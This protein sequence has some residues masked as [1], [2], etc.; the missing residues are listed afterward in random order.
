MSAVHLEELTMRPNVLLATLTV[1]LV[2][3]CY[4]PTRSPKVEETADTADTGAP[5]DVSPLSATALSICGD[6]ET[7]L[8]I[9]SAEEA[10]ET[11]GLSLPIVELSFL[12]QQ[13]R[14]LAEY[15]FDLGEATGNFCSTIDE[16]PTTG[17]IHVIARCVDVHSLT[18]TGEW[19][20]LDSA[21]G[22]HL[23]AEDVY[24][25]DGETVF[26][27]DGEAS[28]VYE[29][30][31]AFSFV[32][33]LFIDNHDMGDEPWTR[34]LEIYA[35]RDGSNDTEAG[36]MEVSSG[37]GGRTGG[38][39]LSVAWQSSDTCEAEGTGETA[40]QGSSLV[41]LT[42]DA[43]TCDGCADVTIDGVAADPYCD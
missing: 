25:N 31:D 9:A 21:E 34:D 38:V 18:L 29:T 22:Y 37:L 24:F 15:F 6:R 27:L 43:E 11:L 3:A 42:S 41:V 14:G 7:T 2:S 8:P 17:E 1:S 10:M 4:M 16:D 33:D 19:S 20:W 35:V 40:L 36:W 12:V 39:C 23:L 5:A 26:S 32:A 30:A 28:F 13:A